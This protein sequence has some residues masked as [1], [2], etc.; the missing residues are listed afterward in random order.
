MLVVLSAAIQRPEPDGLCSV[1][2]M[3]DN[4]T[5]GE[6]IKDKVRRF[7]LSQILNRGIDG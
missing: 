4:A 3:F 5:R 7:V 2:T 6:T 1:K